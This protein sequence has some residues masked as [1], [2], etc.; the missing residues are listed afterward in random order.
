LDDDGRHVGDLPN[1]HVPEGGEL[2]VEYLAD[3]ATLREG[4]AALLDEDGAA[5]VIHRNPDDYRTNPA[6]AG[7]DRIACAVIRG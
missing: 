6:G 5:I 2:E 3:L 1:I 4:E 7:G